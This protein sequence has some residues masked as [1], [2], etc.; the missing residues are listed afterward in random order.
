MLIDRHLARRLVVLYAGFVAALILIFVTFDYVEHVDDMLD[1]GASQAEAFRVYYPNYVPEIIRLTSPLALFLACVFLVGRLAQRFEVMALQAAG[2]SLRRFLAPFLA[3]GALATGVQFYL[4][5]YVVPRTQ[6]VVVAFSDKYLDQDDP[7][8]PTSGLFRQNAPGGYFTADVYDRDRGMA[9]NV[10]LV[11]FD[12]QA[13]AERVDA[14]QMQ[15]DTVALRWHLE[16]PVIQHFRSDGSALRTN[17]ASLDTALNLRPRDLAT[18]LRDV[19]AMTLPEA[20]DYVASVAR[21]GS[22][23]VDAPRVAYLGRFTYPLAHLVLILLGV[24]F[25]VRRQRGGQTVR[26]ALALFVACL[27]LGAQKV[28]EP[29]GANGRMDPLAASLAPHLLVGAAALLGLWR[30]QR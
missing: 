7:Q 27:Y 9:F 15:W 8:D 17:P 19:E 23:A 6:R 22:G 14:I 30:A 3:V 18:S 12:G 24:P 1:R 13:L 4:G 20:R 26:I 5:A 21:T 16:S 2:V 25:A 29:L 10:S 11:R 28:V